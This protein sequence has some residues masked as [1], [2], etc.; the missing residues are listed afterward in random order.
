MYF[1]AAQARV[2]RVGWI[3][4]GSGLSPYILWRTS[5]GSYGDCYQKSKTVVT[6]ARPLRRSLRSRILH[7]M[8]GSSP[9]WSS[10][11]DRF[12]LPTPVR[13]ADFSCRCRHLSRLPTCF[14][15][16]VPAERPS[17]LLTAQRL[18][19]CADHDARADISEVINLLSAISER[20]EQQ[21]VCGDGCME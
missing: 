15:D 2:T 7:T 20:C 18:V 17:C 5:K 13:R 8:F 6:C 4:T 3:D 16:H 19:A 12:G 21:H 11:F 10:D 1:R 9:C 14:P